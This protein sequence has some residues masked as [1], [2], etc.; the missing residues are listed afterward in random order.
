MHPDIGFL[1]EPK[2]MWN[3][4][5]PFEDLVGSYSADP[6]KLFLNAADADHDGG[7]RLTAMYSHYLNFTGN[8][9]VLDKYPELVFRIPFVKA[10]FPDARFVFIVRRGENTCQSVSNWSR[11]HQTVDSDSAT[12]TDWWGLDNRKWQILVE[13]GVRNDPALQVRAQEISAFTRQSD[14]AA[15]EWIL[16]MKTGL[17]EHSKAPESMHLLRYEDLTDNPRETLGGILDFCGLADDP[18]LLDFAERNCNP[19][20][21]H[22]ALEIDS[23]IRHEFE[24]VS[25]LL[26]YS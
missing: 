10:I 5:F 9:R 2:L 18:L 24:R 8:S 6:A 23:V 4:A 26:N 11:D 17:A 22:P 1:N 12:A 3:I 14:M 19:G 16:A 20:T 7:Q 13:Q 21:H 15:I 25:G